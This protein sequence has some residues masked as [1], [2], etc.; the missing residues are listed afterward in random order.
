M[1]TTA[2]SK[3]EKKQPIAV[4]GIQSS[5][6]ENKVDITQRIAE[7]AYYKAMERGF[8]PGYEMEDWLAAEF[9]QSKSVLTC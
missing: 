4:S 9:E 1:A 6:T 8:E 5:S 3:S 7:S 2:L